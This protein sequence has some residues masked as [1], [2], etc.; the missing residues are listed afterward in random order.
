MN[1]SVA[2]LTLSREPSAE[3]MMQLFRITIS[4][5][6]FLFREAR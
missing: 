5:F 6:L 3:V 1:A 2:T 4:S